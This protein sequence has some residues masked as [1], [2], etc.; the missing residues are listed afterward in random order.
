MSLHYDLSEC[1]AQYAQSS[2]QYSSLLRS[3]D[4]TLPCIVIHSPMRPWR[5][6][7]FGQPQ[8][9]KQVA[10][11]CR[12]KP[13]RVGRYCSNIRWLRALVRQI[14]LVQASQCCV[15][16]YRQRICNSSSMQAQLER[17]VWTRNRVIA[18]PHSKHTTTLVCSAFTVSDILWQITRSSLRLVLRFVAHA[19][20]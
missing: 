14:N 17:V 6:T 2:G 15:D 13:C 4:G 16:R 3:V 8:G 12:R 10:S 19:C 9:R 18:R 5:L 1:T 11:Q 20:F 7:R